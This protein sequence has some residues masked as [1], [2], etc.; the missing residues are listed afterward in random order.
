VPHQRW[1]FHSWH[2]AATPVSAADRPAKKAR[3]KRL[4]G[5]RPLARQRDKRADP[6]AQ[7][8]RGDCSAVRRALTDAGPP[9]LA[10]AGLT[11]PDRLSARSQRLERRTNRG[12]CPR[13]SSAYTRSAH[14]A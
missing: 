8:I 12:P 13:R 9:P 5:V 7:G 2:E 6:A 10:A 4:R 11:L 14:G 1:H 3:N